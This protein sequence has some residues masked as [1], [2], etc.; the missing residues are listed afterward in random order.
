M[1]RLEILALPFLACLVLTGIHVYLG[2]HVLARK[3]IFVDIALAQIAALG[4]SVAFLRGDDPTGLPA[5]LWSLLFAVGGAA[6]FALTRTRTERVPQ[7]AVIGLTYAVASAAAILLAARSPHGAEHLKNLLAGSIV[8]VTPAQVGKTAALYAAIGA[9]HFALRRRFLLISLDPEEAYRRGLRVRVWDFV[10]YLTFAVVITSSVQIAGVLLVFC[11]LIAPAVFAALLAGGIGARLAVGW[12]V[13]A[14]VSGA[15]LL[16]SYDRPSGPTIMVCF[17]AALLLAAAA[18]A[19]RRGASRLSRS[20]GAIGCTAAAV[21]LLLLVLPGGE[22]A[23]GI[24]HGHPHGEPEHGLGTSVAELL[25]QLGDEHANVR[26]H[27]AEELAKRGAREAVP[28]LA[29][30]LADPEPGV[31]EKAAEAL[32]ALGDDSAVPSLRAALDRGIDDEWVRLRIA[33][34]LLDLGS[35]AG[36]PPLLDLAERGE[37]RLVRLEA[38]NRCL[39]ARE[40]KAARLSDPDGPAAK[41]ALAALREWWEK[42]REGLRYDPER[43]VF[44]P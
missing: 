21:G 3:V 2:I 35:T 17:A 12:T 9:L 18:R 32:G 30:A 40:E 29:K 16:V 7:E 38:A 39:R 22:R 34:A 13:G 27:A 11:Y 36:I 6:V 28:A 42:E 41:Q 37:A 24:D 8:W 15:G 23:E 25:H 19:A 14:L 26:A 31:V 10:F 20:G 4:G 33:A 44:G 1:N 43:K 5:Y